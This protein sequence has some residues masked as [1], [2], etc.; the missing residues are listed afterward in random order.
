MNHYEAPD[1]A[2]CDFASLLE[3]VSG[4]SGI[5]RIRFASPHP[6]HVSDRMLAAL[7]DLPKVCKHLHL[8]V[9]SGSNR[10]LSA[11]RRRYTREHYLELVDK[12]R[13][14]VPNVTLRT[15]VIVGFPGEADEDFA[16]TYSLVETQ[17]PRYRTEEVTR[18]EL[19]VTV[20]ATG[21][22]QP[23]NQVDVGS[24]LSGTIEAVL[25]DDNDRVQEGPGP[26]AARPLQAPGPGRQSPRA[27]LASAE[28]QVLQVRGDRRG[29]ARPTW[30]A[31]AR[32]PSCPAA[33]CRPRP[34]S[35]PRRRR[36]TR[37]IANEADADAAV[38]TGQRLAQ[39][40]RD[41]PRQGVDPL[42]DRRRGA[43]AQGGAGPDRGGI[44]PG[45]G[46]V[47]AGRGPGA[48]GAAGGRGRG[49][50]G[51]GARGPDRDLHR[52]CLRRAASTRRASP[53][54]ATA[55]R[56]RSGVVSYKTIL[57]VDNDD[58]S[59]RPGMTATAEI[60]TAKRE[61]VLL[62]PNAALRFT[63]PAATAPAEQEE[64][65]P[66]RQPASAAAEPDSRQAPNDPRDNGK[67][68]TQQ[69]W[70]LRDGEPV[71]VPVTIGRQQRPPDRGD[72]RR[73]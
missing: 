41:Q 68:G 15:D 36:W 40:R 58:L 67:S 72:R 52:G 48:D 73:T 59:L 20:S 39:I 24:E 55:R 4:V 25:V 29:V 23:T 1:D 26:R 13:A 19:V 16:E 46:A 22:L 70:V 33:R 11:M 64:R 71:A 63:P 53:A 10:I 54:S 27:T 12:A 50:R 9:Q 69:V 44:L 5:E 34:S 31:C 57:K 65:Q 30:R 45:A 38:R 32:S 2:S 60:T 28:A 6:R 66:R 49:R 42:A 62:V 18:G 47:H 43:D 17:A 14:E 61:N 3:R 8:P 51:P 35:K 56:P 7:R 37:A 21:N